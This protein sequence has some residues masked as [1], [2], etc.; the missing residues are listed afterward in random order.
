MRKVK[1]FIASSLDGYIARENGATDW[2]YSDA[3]YG[4][5]QFYNSVDI[6]VMGRKTYDKVLDFGTG[7][8]YKDKKNYVFTQKSL[9]KRTEKDQNVHFIADVIEFIKELVQS[10]GKDI[11]LVGGAEIISIFLNAKMLNE[12]TLSIHP[13]I[14]G[15][16]IPLFKNL[17]GQLNLKLV[18][19]IPY[20]NGLMQLH[21]IS[22]Y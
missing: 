8:P 14:L 4:Y 9:G 20:E 12:I 10:P 16:G 15:K 7:Y 18:K 5:A 11:W 21:Y 13:I 1:L 22:E 6:V 17:Q 2:L 19:S 3:D